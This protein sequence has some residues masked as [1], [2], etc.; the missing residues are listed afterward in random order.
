MMMADVA[1][2]DAGADVEIADAAVGFVAAGD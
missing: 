2:A 1:G